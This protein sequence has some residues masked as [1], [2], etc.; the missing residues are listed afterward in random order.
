MIQFKCF[1]YQM[2]RKAYVLT[3]IVLAVMFVP[4]DIFYFMGNLVVPCCYL[5]LGGLLAGLWDWGG[6][7]FGSVY[8]ALYFALFYLL[9]RVTYGLIT[10]VKTAKLRLALQVSV[11]VLVFSCS[12]LRVITNTGF[13]GN[14]GTYNFWTASVRYLER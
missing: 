5:I 9:A 12:F 8:V 11:L 3:F 13:R 10:R 6:I 7:F 2:T 14:S 4:V 1:T